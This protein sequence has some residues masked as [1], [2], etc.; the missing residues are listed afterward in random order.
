[1]SDQ[2][3]LR[4]RPLYDKSD[5]VLSLVC[6]LAALDVK[7]LR[8]VILSDTLNKD[9]KDQAYQSSNILVSALSDHA[10]LVVRDVINIPKMIL[11]KLD[12]I[13]ASKTT[14]TKIATISELFSKKLTGLHENMAY[15]VYCLASLV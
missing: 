5:Y 4:I 8:K 6:I 10:L 15:H 9:E 14:A 12:R 11:Y 3:K 1:M 2:E 7:Q 13:Y